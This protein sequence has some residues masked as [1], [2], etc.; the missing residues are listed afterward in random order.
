MQITLKREFL[1]YRK[2]T[3]EAQ[4]QGGASCR[5][6]N[7]KRERFSEEESNNKGNRADGKRTQTRGESNN[8][9]KWSKVQK[10]MKVKKHEDKGSYNYSHSLGG[11]TKEEREA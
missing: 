4:A 6:W 2:E 10:K 3:L 11:A 5:F 7:D 1:N 8:K 9:A